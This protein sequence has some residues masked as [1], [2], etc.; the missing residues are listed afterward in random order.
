VSGAA[1]IAARVHVEAALVPGA[2]I[3]LGAGPAHHLR[4]VLRLQPGDA[5]GVFNAHDGEFAAS[6]AGFA[7]GAARVTIGARR[8]APRLEPDLWLCFA[9]I[10]RARLD[11]MVEKATEL[12]VSRLMPVFTRHTAMERVNG[13]RLT[14]IAV[15]AAGQCER[16]SVPV[17]DA[18][19]DLADLLARWPA[20][21]QLIVAD[22]S[23][24]GA[25][26]AA[27]LDGLAGPFG[28]LTGPEGGFA[29]SELDALGRAVFVRRVGLGPRILRADTAA[30]ATLAILQA[31]V[32]DGGFAPRF[33]DRDGS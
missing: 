20:R 21:R 9:P 1:R 31:I 22:E 6:I 5:I 13:E 19:V 10:K 8:R 15:E 26:I 27:A 12:G 2:G 14:A 33:A 32:G 24:A 18:P 4:N 30:I 3:E 25:P 17:V 23:G 28:V 29:S 11:A 7:K 16:L